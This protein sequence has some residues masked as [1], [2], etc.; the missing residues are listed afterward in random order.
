MNEVSRF[1]LSVMIVGVALIATSATLAISVIEPKDSSP[2]PVRAGPDLTI[3]TDPGTGCQYVRDTYRGITARMG[4][5]GKPI[6]GLPA[7]AK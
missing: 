2:E 4:I 7:V 5:D 3:I 6:C 1:G